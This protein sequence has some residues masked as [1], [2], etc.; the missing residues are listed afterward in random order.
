[1]KKLIT[2]ILCVIFLSSCTVAAIQ[3]ESD[4]VREET[5]F[6]SEVIFE[7]ASDVKIDE[8]SEMRG[9]WVSQFDMK[10]IYRDGNK[11]RSKEDFTEKVK[12]LISNLKRDGF[13]TVFLQVRPNGDSMY[14]SEIYPTSKY[15]AGAYGGDIGYDAIEIFLSVA[16]DNGISVHAWINPFRL[17]SEDELKQG[18]FGKLSEW[19]KS[20]LGR[21]IKVGSNGILYLDPYY[22]EATELIVSGAREIL[23]K[24]DFDG[25]H[26]DDYFYPT[27]FEFD[28]DFEF[29]ESGYNDKGEFRRDNI[30]RTVK[31]LYNA[32]HEFDGKLFGVSPA[33]N[34]YSLPK[35]WYADIHKWCVEDGFLDYVVPQLY[36]GFENAVCPFMKIISDWE[37]AVKNEKI[38]LYIGLSAAKCANGTNGIEDK[39]AGEKGKYEWRDNKD[40]LARSVRRIYESKNAKGFVIFTYSSFYDPLTGEENPLTHDE[41]KNF[42]MSIK[43]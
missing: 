19:Y 16:K 39:F 24:Y 12:V 8:E 43:K 33:G 38:S 22:E 40:I 9:I 6:V 27:E 23:Q 34:I 1:M 2:V 14:E 26:I 29:K 31:A 10:P 36:F 21:R 13:N 41:K 4:T 32:V 25:I 7:S 3:E 20:S 18:G 30:S 37:S 42:D 15:I 5:F 17:T 35:K 11:Q 28:D